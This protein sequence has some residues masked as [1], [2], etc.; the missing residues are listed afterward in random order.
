[1]HEETFQLKKAATYG[2]LLSR[3]TKNLVQ[4]T[5]QCCCD[6]QGRVFL[7]EMNASDSNLT[8]VRPSPT[9]FTSAAYQQRTG[10]RIDEEFRNWTLGKPRA[11]SQLK[12]AK[13]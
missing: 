4:K 8:L 10:F 7:N 11:V 6:P 9:K 3:A 12:H 13:L 1:L 5:F 2:P